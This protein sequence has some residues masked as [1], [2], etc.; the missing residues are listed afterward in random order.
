MSEYLS[1]VIPS[2][3]S[4]VI[5]R[6]ITALLCQTTCLSVPWEIYVV[7]QD[8]PGLVK[9]Q[10]HVHLL[11]TPVPVS[12]SVARNLGAER[13]DGELLIFLDADCIPQPG[14]LRAMLAAW[15]RWPDAGAISGAMLPDGDSLVLH[16]GQIAGFHEH[17][18]CTL[19]SQRSALASFSL[20]VPREMW[21]SVGG[22]DE[23][24]KFAAAE[25]LD[26]TIRIA[27]QGRKLYLTNSAA[28]RHF[29][30]RGNW[31]LLWEHAY[32]AGSQ[33][34]KVRLQHI[35]YYDMPFWTTNPKVW[36][37]MAPGIAAVRSVQ[38]YTH[39]PGLWKY[40]KC[41][42]WVLISKIAWC[43]G[44]A[45]GLSSLASDEIGE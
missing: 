16:C 30:S 40:W 13:A 6:V 8:H 21:K 18:N 5:D 7:G 11:P 38:I 15:A 43:W 23:S 37:I 14:W 31:K 44:A 17:L 28:V 24:F 29:P 26:F 39:T 25:D 34:I 36:R 22:F 4:L 1:F 45:A 19:S 10:A 35:D 41:A 2:L 12:P 3:N 32:R 42:P 20:L 9:A 33:S 27:R